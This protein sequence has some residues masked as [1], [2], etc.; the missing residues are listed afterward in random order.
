MFAE[1]GQLEH[2]S[3]CDT[4]LTTLTRHMDKEIVLMQALIAIGKLAGVN[5]E[6]KV[7]ELDM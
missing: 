4:V 2:L 6:N 5:N 7:S 1:H 3:L